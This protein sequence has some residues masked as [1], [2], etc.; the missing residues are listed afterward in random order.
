MVST[1]VT[2]AVIVSDL[3]DFDFAKNMMTYLFLDVHRK[4]RPDG[5]FQL[6]FLAN[7]THAIL[8]NLENLKRN[9]N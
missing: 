2:H 1:K 7:P 6:H 3:L 4:G 5:P 8:A 9:N